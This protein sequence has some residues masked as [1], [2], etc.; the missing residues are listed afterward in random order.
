MPADAIDSIINTPPRVTQ[1]Q[2]AGQR[3]HEEAHQPDNRLESRCSHGGAATIV[4]STTD[5]AVTTASTHEDLR[6]APTRSLRHPSSQMTIVSRISISSS[7]A[8]C[9][10]VSPLLRARGNCIGV[11]ARGGD[12]LSGG[13]NTP[14]SAATVDQI[15][16]AK[17]RP[18]RILDG[19]R[20]CS[21][22]GEALFLPPHSKLAA[23]LHHFAVAH[24]NFKIL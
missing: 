9:G 16:T 15:R 24:V 19:C 6:E 2:V 22:C 4:A 17:S 3:Q 13:V 5:C 10:R 1:S 7:F 11:G 8:M 20:I 14:M 18:T 21:H 12:G 23:H